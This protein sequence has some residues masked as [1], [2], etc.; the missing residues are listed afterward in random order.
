MTQQIG[1]AGQLQPEQLKEVAERG[2]KSVINNRPD[3]EEGAHQP[4]NEQVQAAAQEQG[5]NYVFQP[6]I[7][8]QITQ[9]DVEAFANYVNELPKPVLAFCRTGNRCN[10]LYQMA[11]QMDL[12]DD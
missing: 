9:Q 3:F 1:F 2:F 6:V 11:K 7:S 12:I 10:N 5:L 8:G 4:T